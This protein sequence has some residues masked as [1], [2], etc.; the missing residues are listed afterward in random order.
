MHQ[1]VFSGQR[2]SP[3]AY[4]HFQPGRYDLPGED[5]TLG[6]QPA[7]IPASQPSRHHLR[8]PG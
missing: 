5:A 7:T 6:S 1:A 2:L 4:P 3:V 8:I